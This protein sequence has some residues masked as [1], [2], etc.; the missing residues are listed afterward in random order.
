VALDAYFSDEEVERARGYERPQRA[1]GAAQSALALVTLAA[2]ARQARVPLRALGVARAARDGAALSLTL[3]GVGLP[4]GALARKRALNVGLATQSW[5]DWGWD[6]VRAGVL[7]AT[8]AGGAAAAVWCLIDRQGERWWQG[9]AAGGLALAA[10]A[11]FAGPV[12]LDP[13]FNNFDPLPDG[14]LRSS[15]FELAD[16]A[17]VN[18]GEV[19]S[20][21][22]SRRSEA[23][24][25]YVA[26]IGATRRIVLFDTLLEKL[27]APETRLV[28]AHELAHVR[29]RDVMRGLLFSGLVSPAMVRAVARLAP[30]PTSDASQADATL[31]AL[32]LSGA[33]TALLTGPLARQLSR[34]TERRAD[35]FALEL[36]RDPDTFIGFEQQVTRS[37]LADPQPPRWYS[38]LLATHPPALERIGAAAAFK[39]AGGASPRRSP[40]R[41]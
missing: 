38:L 39:A 4:L 10:I 26:G 7:N 25:A 29:H 37:N 1:I 14:E 34:A 20:V 23:V 12:L 22:A 9:A 2:L 41:P 27:S 36:T 33:V 31:P 6:L 19:Y 17:G 28:V 32:A 40:P 11:S 35:V 13:I 18:L 24:N 3:A 16:R 5:R 30:F 8:F 15:I 21:D